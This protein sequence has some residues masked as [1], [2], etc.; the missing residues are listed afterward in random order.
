MKIL[1][2]IQQPV[3][4]WQIP[5]PQVER[6]RALFPQHEFLYATDDA[7]RAAGLAACDVA[8]TWI[9]KPHELA[10]APHVRWVHT[11]AVAVGTLCLSDLAAR[12]IVVSN[13][14]GVQARPI[15]EHV[16]ACVLAFARQLPFVLE[17]QR[18]ATWSQNAH[19]GARL[20]WLLRGRTLGVVGLGSIGAEIASLATAWDL[21]VVG[22]RRRPEAGGPPGVAEVLGIDGLPRLLAQSDIVVV[23]APLTDDTRALLGADEIAAMKPGAVL[24]NIARGRLVDTTALIAALESGHLAGAALDVFDREPLP[25]DHPLWRAPNVLLTPHTSGFRA[26]HWDEVVDLFAD[27]LRRYERGEPVRWAVDPALGY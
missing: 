19:A 7:G 1:V 10:A 26:G 4:A 27:N 24:V 17:Q 15:A 8:F 21:R 14:R 23:A 16:F 6:L 22:V 11:S 5:A 9:L 2:S 18:T 3:A 20:P 25:T 12:G 13:T